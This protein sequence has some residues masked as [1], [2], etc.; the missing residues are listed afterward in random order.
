MINTAKAAKVELFIWSRLMSVTEASGGIYIH[1]DHFDGKTA[2]TAY[3]RQSSVPFVDVQAGMCASNFTGALTPQK[4]VDG[5]Y[6]IALPFGPE[7]L[8]LV[9][10]MASDY[11]LFVRQAIESPAFG[12]SS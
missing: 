12:V 9:I 7:T 11:G 2:I 8:L 10:D 5:S 3:G 6:A 1:L 4:Q